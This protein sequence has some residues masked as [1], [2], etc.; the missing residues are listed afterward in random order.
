AYR[1]AATDRLR[2]YRPAE[3]LP[4]VER[5]LE[6]ATAADVRAALLVIKGDVLLDSGRA[7][8]AL[9]AYQESLASGDDKRERSLALLG[10]ASARR[11]LD[12]LEG[13]L[14]DVG[15]AQALA[16]KAQA[17]A[18]DG[19]WLEIKARCHFIR[20][21]LFFPLGRVDECLREHQAALE[22]AELSGDA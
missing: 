21:N 8:D 15:K 13:A 16:E 17:L 2:Q 9:S 10:S 3:A 4:L 12:Q 18:E 20:G 11:I 6:L 1:I 19:G 7:R 22:H 5:G 14:D